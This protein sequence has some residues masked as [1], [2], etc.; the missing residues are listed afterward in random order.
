MKTP[1]RVPTSDSDLLRQYLEDNLQSAFEDLVQRHLPLVY[2]VAHRHLEGS[3]SEAEDIAQ[4][5]FLRLARQAR[6]LV[7]HP[8]VS[9]WCFQTT[10]HV[11]LN[12][13]RSQLRRR[14]RELAIANGPHSPEN[15]CSWEELRP[16]LDD[17]LEALP[18][19]DREVV[20]WRYF[21]LSPHAEIGGRL[22][23]QENAARMRV[24]R[25]LEKLREQLERRSITSTAAA[26]GLL[27]GQQVFATPPPDLAGR[28]A[29]YAVA[30][31]AVTPWSGVLMA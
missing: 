15:E 5:V 24:E 27:L 9:G 3:S 6:E 29:R 23:I 13:R 26:L 7:A 30:P 25:A 22:G 8:S 2:G 21:E 16:V 17:A 31:A 11:V 19:R 14:Q 18:P 10:R 1:L 20:L 28:I 12:H 4:E